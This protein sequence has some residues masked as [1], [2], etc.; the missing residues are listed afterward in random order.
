M[1]TIV[2]LALSLIFFTQMNAQKIDSSYLVANFEKAEYF[3]EMRDGI[4]LFTL[5]Y[6]PRAKGDFPYAAQCK[7]E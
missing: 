4:K 7:R 1:K 6:T 3:I 2:S 5:V